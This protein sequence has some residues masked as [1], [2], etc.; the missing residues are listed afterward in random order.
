M[1]RRTKPVQPVRHLSPRLRRFIIGIVV[2][3]ILLGVFIVSVPVA[4]LILARSA[5]A[6]HKPDVGLKWLLIAAPFR[7]RRGEIEFLRARCYR[8]LGNADE[9]RKSIL[10]AASHGYPKPELEREQVLLLAQLGRLREVDPKISKILQTAD[11]DSAEVCEAYVSG[12]LL[13]SR[14]TEALTVLDSWC[15]DYPADPYP[16]LL[17][18]QI[19]QSSQRYPEAE[20][21]YR[22][23]QK[24]STK[25]EMISLLIGE[26]QLEARET[27]SALATFESLK[28]IMKPADLAWLRLAKCH[29]I[30]GN[31]PARQAA[32]SHIRQ[33]S[34]LPAGD[35]AMERGILAL[36]LEQFDEAIEQLQRAKQSQPR[37]IEVGN[38]LATALRASGQREDGDREAQRVATMESELLRSDRLQQE[39]ALHPNDFEIRLEI[40]KILLQYGDAARGKAWVQSVIN[41]FPGHRDANLILANYYESLGDSSKQYAALASQYRSRAEGAE[42]SP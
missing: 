32:L 39:L 31:I 38:A 2:T 14:E 19:L 9:F 27:K 10:A 36:D 22:R 34:G 33:E 11:G 8:K 17:R 1:S 3:S 30:L 29:R 28:K 41:L 13:N 23:A 6:N 12:L 37:S 18:G 42:E 24:L 20:A 4:G 5:I 15:K 40:G 25:S 35:L 7:Q 26:L 21:S 16:E